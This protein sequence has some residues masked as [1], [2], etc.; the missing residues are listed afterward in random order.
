MK[1]R[2]MA[3]LK[4]FDSMGEKTGWTYIEVPAGLAQQ[5]HPSDKNLFG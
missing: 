2:F 5:L 1:I 3:T 4:R